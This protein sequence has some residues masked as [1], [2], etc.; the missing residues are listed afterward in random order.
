MSYVYVES[1]F[2][3]AAYP[4]MFCEITGSVGTKSMP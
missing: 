2:A 4:C 1:C 3:V